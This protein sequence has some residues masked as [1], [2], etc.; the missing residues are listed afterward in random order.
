MASFDEI[1][2]LIYSLR[3]SFPISE[4]EIHTLLSECL[5]KNKISYIHEAKLGEKSR[6]DFLIGDIGIEIKK[7]RPNKTSLLKQ[8]T[9]YS[10]SDK[11]SC[12][13]LLCEQ[14][15]HLQDSINSK[16]LLSIS[17]RK[18][19]G[20]LDA[21]KDKSE[22][23]NKKES[24]N[25]KNIKK[26]GF[27]AIQEPKS[28]QTD[29]PNAENQHFLIPPY[30]SSKASSESEG[31]HGVLSYHKGRKAWIIKAEPYVTELIKRLFPGSSGAKRGQAY[32][33]DNPRQVGEMNWLMQRY[34]LE[35]AAKDRDRFFSQ[36]KK[37][38]E[39]A[40]NLKKLKELSKSDIAFKL[41]FEAKLLPFQKE[42]VTWLKLSQRA[43][44]ADEMGLGKTIQSLA[45]ISSRGELP[46]III[47]PAHLV[48]NWE[49]EINRFVSKDGKK[50]SVHRFKGLK[51]YEPPK[52]DIY[53]M[54][55]LLLR[56]WKEALADLSFKMVI[57]DEIQELRHSGTEKYSAASLLSQA[58]D[59]VIGLSGTPIYNHGG[60]IWNVINIIDYHLLGDWESF[61]REWCY[62]Y[63][64]NIVAKPKLLGE[65]L[66]NEGVMLRRTK[67]EVLSELPE[68]RRLV[69]EIDIN[70]P[71][72]KSK[73]QEIVSKIREY[74]NQALS[75]QEKA[76][77]EGNISNAERQATGL[78]KA[79]YVAQFVRA[80][81]ENGEKVLLFAHHHSVIDYFKKDLKALS[82][83]FITGR[84]TG[85]QKE[86]SV[87]RFMNGKTDLCC[88]SLRAAAGLNLQ[89]ASCVV[90]AELDW[91]PAVHSQAEDRAHRIGQRDS[92]L[93]YYLVSKDGSDQD[94]QNA[95]GLKVSQFVQL[96]GES[97]Q[98]ENEVKLNES[99]AR[100]HVEHILEKLNKGLF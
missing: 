41:S 46:I 9:K 12:L 87:E 58:C 76:L 14:S 84:E 56:G 82:P 70:M 77:L 62:G 59:N 95:L 7:S 73:M 57:F 53:I 74:Q 69:Q 20:F 63:G 98:D 39:R 66:R 17:L 100:K 94:I 10:L 30:L 48:T 21:K 18:I 83:A 91:S 43:L 36:L 26:S 55:Y 42:G 64:N 29:Y 47:V 11:I 49:N 71:A 52:A 72:Y 2:N 78:A 86:K 5:D 6:I 54:H 28:L 38:R 34:P 24:K 67:S 3:P 50:L 89:R 4:G 1:R 80:L 32:F 44:L 75:K 31:F 13:I 92:L 15:I 93:C 60:E 68:K 99:L 61:T 45:L 40:K 65:F 8:L 25:K 23:G 16:P 90:F 85:A 51:P 35:I 33:A 27:N 96:M 97:E 81:I 22:A 19:M 88:I 37:A 79:P